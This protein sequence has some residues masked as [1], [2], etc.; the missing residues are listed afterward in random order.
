M[1]LTDK[2]TAI[3]NAIRAKNGTTEKMTLEQMS[4]EISEISGGSGSSDIGKL[5]D[6][7]ITTLDISNGVTKIRN[8]AFSYCE[9]LTSVTI[10]NSVTSI[11]DSAFRNCTSLT[12][13][14]IPNGV[15]RISS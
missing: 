1:A 13:V 3:A 7:S 10:P 12:S 14:T 8:Y 9:R 4:E 5:V 2:L 6:G 15:T 11:G